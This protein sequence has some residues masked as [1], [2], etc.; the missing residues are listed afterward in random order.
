MTGISART[1]ASTTSSR[2]RPP[3][4]LTA[5]APART[6]VAALRTA[7]CG[8]EVVAHPRHVAQDQAARFG[9]GHRGGVMGHHVD[10][11]VERVVETQHGIG[12]RVADEDDVDPRLRDDARPRLVVSR[13]HDDRHAAVA[14][15]ALPQGGNGDGALAH[16]AGA[17]FFRPL[18]TPGGVLP[19]EVVPGARWADLDLEAEHRLGPPAQ[20][21]QLG[22]RSWATTTGRQLGPEDEGNG[23]Q[24]AVVADGA[25]LL[26]R[27]THVPGGPQELGVGVAH[28][29]LLDA[30]PLH[31]A[32][33][34]IPHDP[35]LDLGRDIRAHGSGRGPRFRRDGHGGQATPRAWNRSAR[36]RQFAQPTR[37]L[38][39]Q[40][41]NDAISNRY[42]GTQCWIWPSSD[43]SRSVTSTATKSASS[44]VSTWGC[45]RTSRSGRSTRP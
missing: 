14:S 43:S 25:D 26:G 32:D 5:W 1:M 21:L 7:S 10:V 44:C 39:D 31:L 45:W 17:A 27:P 11:D 41:L 29:D 42:S 35:V 9:P 36:R 28:V 23:D 12:H 2:A 37:R 19:H 4:S 8:R 20:G 16:R 38:R 30:A 33:Q 40:C 13:D 15:L 6:R 3:S 24:A 34:P 18:W 22:D